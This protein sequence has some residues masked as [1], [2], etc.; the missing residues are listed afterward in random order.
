MIFVL[1]ALGL[2][3]SLPDPFESDPSRIL[4]LDNSGFRSG[5]SVFYADFSDGSSGIRFSVSDDLIGTICLVPPK[6][7]G[8]SSQKVFYSHILNEF[9]AGIKNET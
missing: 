7:R 1:L 2:A 9:L 4:R 8:Q 6:N 5:V 3:E